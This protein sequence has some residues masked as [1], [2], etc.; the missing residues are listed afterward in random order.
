MSTAFDTSIMSVLMSAEQGELYALLDGARDDAVHAFTRESGCPW[1]YLEE[2]VVEASYEVCAPRLIALGRRPSPA[3]ER[4]LAQGWGHSWGVFVRTKAGFG[5]L[6][7]HLRT[8]SS[9]KLPNGRV[10]QFR[11]YDPRVLRLYLPTCTADELALMFGP[12]LEYLMEAETPGRLCRFARID[13]PQDE[14][15]DDDEQASS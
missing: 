6:R 1:V 9:V 7:R 10:A 8:L 13:R 2:A 14:E 15:E 12:V 5:R 4:L 3:L 11:F